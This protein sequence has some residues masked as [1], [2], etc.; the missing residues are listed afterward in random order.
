GNGPNRSHGGRTVDMR[1]RLGAYLL[2]ASTDLVAAD[3]TAARI[4]SH[5]PNRVAQLGMAHDMGLG[6][7]R[8][9]RIELIGP[10][11]SELRVNW[12]P[13]RIGGQALMV[14]AGPRHRSCP[15]RLLSV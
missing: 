8:K 9:D 10:P 14:S 12:D 5:D 13:A 1:D 11:L 7:M 15:G 3:A 4:M 2:L 6:E